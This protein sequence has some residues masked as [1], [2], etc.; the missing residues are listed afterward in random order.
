MAKGGGVN[1]KIEVKVNGLTKDIAQMALKLDRLRDPLEDSATYME[2]SIAQRFRSGGGSRPWKPLSPTTIKRHPHRAGG[3]P[4]NDTG[5]L[6]M[7]V[8]TGASQ[9]IS[10]GKL[11]YSLGSGVIY[12]ATHN[13][14][15]GN[16]PQR[17][18]LYFDDKDEKMIQRIFETYIKE[19]IK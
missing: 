7:S 15:R 6:K 17:E 19:L 10:N 1:V 13:F 11:N 18:F 14:G 8:T 3:R 9:R 12:G 5:R 4:L 2:S 16:I